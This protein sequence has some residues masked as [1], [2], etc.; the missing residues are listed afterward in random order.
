MLP[1]CKARPFYRVSSTVTSTSFEE[2]LKGTITP[3]KYADLVVLE[4]DPRKVLPRRI[5]DVR[6]LMTVVGGQVVYQ[7]DADSTS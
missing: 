6:V 5:Q 2:N 7:S 4:D 3:G 1:T